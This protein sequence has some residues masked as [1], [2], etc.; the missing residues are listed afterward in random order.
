MADQ[1]PAQ[2]TSQSETVNVLRAMLKDI[3]PSC[4]LDLNSGEIREDGRLTYEVRAFGHHVGFVY[5]RRGGSLE[6]WI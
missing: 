1:I 4:R 2:S 3:D 6:E 5:I